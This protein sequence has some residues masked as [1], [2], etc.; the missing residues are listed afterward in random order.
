MSINGMKLIKLKEADVTKLQQKIN[1][2]KP[3]L[4]AELFKAMGNENRLKIL[5]SLLDE[6]LCVYD[7]SS[8]IG[9]SISAVS[10]VSSANFLSKSLP[11][12]LK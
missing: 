8:V 5:L 2:K 1:E 10:P 7:I 6:E 12:D 3:K 4:V 9:L 11:S